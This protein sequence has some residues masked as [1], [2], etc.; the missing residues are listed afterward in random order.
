M[1]N[2]EKGQKHVSQVFDNWTDGLP[3]FGPV[4]MCCTKCPHRSEPPGPGQIKVVC[5][6][7]A[8]CTCMFTKLFLSQFIALMSVIQLTADRTWHC[9]HSI[10][11]AHFPFTCETIAEVPES[12][13]GNACC[14]C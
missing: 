5:V 13:F 7:K 4:S 6:L 14:R 12:E 10:V 1:L 2:L 8:S 9:L 3:D 11:F